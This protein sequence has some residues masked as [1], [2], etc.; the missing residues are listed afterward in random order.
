MVSID[1]KWVEENILLQKVNLSDQTLLNEVFD[2]VS[3][4]TGDEIVTQG[5]PGGHLYILRYGSAAITQKINGKSIYL[6]Q[7]DEGALFGEM[8]FLNGSPFSATVTAHSDCLTYRLDLQGYCKLL[9][10][11]PEMLMSLFTYIL[12]CSSSA[13]KQMNIQYGAT[14]QLSMI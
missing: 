13:L 5:H 6:G 14:N 7:A 11:N 9:T 12:N 3:Y 10:V 4:Q 2:L 1:Y 8:S